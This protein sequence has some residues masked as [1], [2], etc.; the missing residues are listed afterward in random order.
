MDKKRKINNALETT[1]RKIRD[2][3]LLS[4]ATAVCG[5]VLKKA[6]DNKKTEHERLNDII[7]FCERS[8]GV[9]KKHENG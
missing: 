9:A 1:A 7:G 2:N 4:G 8:L 3:A 5:V 6:K